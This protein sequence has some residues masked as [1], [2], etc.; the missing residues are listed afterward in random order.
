MIAHWTGYVRAVLLV[1][2]CKKRERGGSQDLDSLGLE[3][4][5]GE[6]FD[7]YPG[8]LY[9]KSTNPTKMGYTGFLSCALAPE[10]S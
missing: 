5:E 3:A 1:V 4:V 8:L 10:G 9:F 2:S 6:V 7:R